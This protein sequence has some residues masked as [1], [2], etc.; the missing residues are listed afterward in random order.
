M[1]LKY[2]AAFVGVCLC[3]PVHKYAYAT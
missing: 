2:Q 1:T 3:G